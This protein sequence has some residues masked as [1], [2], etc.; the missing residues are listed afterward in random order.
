MEQIISK[1]KKHFYAEVFLLGFLLL[2]A[3]IILVREFLIIFN[4][5]ELVIGILFFIWMICTALGAWSG[6]FLP[7][8]GSYRGLI[9][10]LL[11]LIALYPIIAALGVELLRN[12]IF[13]TGRLISFYE[14]LYFSSI[15]LLPLCFAGGL[16]FSLINISAENHSGNLQDCYS[17]ESVG[18]LIGGLVTSII[19]IFYLKTDNF[20]TLQY[21]ALI[22]FIYFGI[23][24]FKFKRHFASF[25]YLL[26]A[27]GIMH[28]IYSYDLS[29]YA[30]KSLY[31]GQ[32]LISAKDTPF[33]NLTVTKQNNQTNVYM[34]GQLLHSSDN[35]IKREENVHYALLQNLEAENVLMLG[36]GIS[37]SSSEVFKYPSVKSLDYVE[38]NESLYHIA[39]ELGVEEVKLPINYFFSD[40]VFYVKNCSKTYDVVLINQPVPS[41]ARS[42]RLFTVEFFASLKNVLNR[43]GVIS[44]SL[45]SS[46][47]Y[48]GDSELLM[49][50]SI[51]NSLLHSFE[52]VILIPG[53]S[54]YFLAS[55]DS[56]SFYYNV[57]FNISSVENTYVNSSYID[58]NLLRLR[59]KQITSGYSSVAAMNKNFKPVVYSVY[60]NHWLSHFDISFWIIP[61]ICLL[62]VVGYLSFS[63]SHATAMFTSGFTG[64][65]TELLLI[66]TFQ[67]IFGYVYIFIGIII[68]TF[69]AGLALG[70]RLSRSSKMK[71]PLRML[72]F[73]QFFSGIY[74]GSIA[75]SIFYIDGLNSVI[76]VKFIFVFMMFFVAA[77][78]GLQYGVS[79]CYK[80]MNAGTTVSEIYAS[81]LAGSAVASLLLV[82]WLIPAIGIYL[83]LLM[84]TGFHFLTIGIIAMKR[85]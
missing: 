43:G 49:Q 33:G 25:I 51:Y 16:A 12:S 20:L 22:A 24:E 2:S 50:S 13:D 62:L 14:I 45:P 5:N 66:I 8:N 56:L 54:N 52:N 39:Q 63:R 65:A 77:L 68:T 26:G 18:S 70:S 72:Y 28:I 27:I 47:N 3:Q 44:T 41:S 1:E 42:N 19:F 15:V 53:N 59:S 46:E 37:G 61:F 9:R 6:K 80:N 78:T 69:M 84:L 17:Y 85:K 35:I 40:P 23:S 7:S 79:V 4:G 83:S 57:L 74:I 76:L 29:L 38:Q 82:I 60:I 48:L 34:D 67:V 30:K 55:D 73:V 32:Q 10:I 36:G 11:I 71:N 58:D 31:P 21:L 81:D 75:L 64:A